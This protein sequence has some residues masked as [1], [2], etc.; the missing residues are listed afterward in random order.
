MQQNCTT[1][2]EGLY[3][4]EL[5]LLGAKVAEQE[6]LRLLVSLPRMLDL[7][8][9]L[10]LLFARGIPELTEI[11]M[12]TKRTREL[13][14]KMTGAGEVLQREMDKARSVSIPSFCA[15]IVPKCQVCGNHRRSKAHKRICGGVV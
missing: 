2:E 15:S 1:T 9:F 8:T 12:T 5:A 14:R 6:G 7:T 3:S 4:H 13:Y 11:D 10:S